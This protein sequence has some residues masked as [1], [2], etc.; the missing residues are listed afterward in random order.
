MWVRHRQLAV[1]AAL[2]VGLFVAVPGATAASTPSPQR[3]T[4]VLQTII[5]EPPAGRHNPA[6]EA[7]DDTTKVLRVGRTMVPLADGS[8]PTT[9]DGST[10]SVT[11]APAADGTKEVL[12]ADTVSAPADLTVSS[13]H[14]VYVALVLP[15]GVSTDASITDASARAMVA[16]V[17]GYWSS[18]TGGKVSFST[19]QVLPTYRSAYS[20]ASSSSTYNMWDEALR[21]MPSAIGPGKHLVLVAPGSAGALGCPYGLGSV[22]AVEAT[23]N[24]VF[25]SSLNQSLLA[26]E[27]GHNLGLYHSNSLRCSG[28]QDVTVVNHAFPG[29]QSNAYD[30]LFDV[31]GYSGTSYGEGNLNAVHL[32]GMNLLPGAVRKIAANSGVTTARITP[33]STTADNRTLRITDPGGATYFV[34]Y[35]TNS[36]RDT[37]AARNPWRP[38]WG[39]RVLRSDPAH[40]ASSG[41]YELDGT[42]TSLSY[43]YNRSIPVGGTFTSASRGLTIRVAAQDTTGATLTIT[44][45]SAPLVPYR[46]TQSVPAK[47]LVG[48]GVTAATRVT[49]RQGSAVP[50]WTVTLQ[51]QQK[52]TTTWRSVRSLRTGSTGAASYW[53]A[54]GVS[55]NYRWVTSATT[56]TPG[57]TSASVSLTS[58]ARVHNK[59]PATSMTRATYLSVVGS[60][61]PV[62]GPVVYI[63]YRYAGG[64]WQTGPR[65]T[66]KGTAVT[67]R[68]RLSVRTTA[69][70]RLYVRPATSYVGSI[71]GYHVTTVR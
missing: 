53:F 40:P 57:R 37:V 48:A 23:S 69:Y 1:P 6:N 4:G 11:V 61:S 58:T 12:A 34:E 16:T 26:H 42:P 50:N 33:L 22:G 13:T 65:A 7:P 35:R 71:S 15:A 3:I 47:A 67:G 44:D 45:V 60:V 5:H 24:V 39:V 20:C 59:V 62:P 43:D 25:V 21:K 49:N 8:L 63:Q 36:G 27:L 54:N 51:K 10:V 29:C 32:D 70:T 28:T 2:V 66:V 68:I 46:V 19:A 14:Q 30:D 17:S 41:S 55:G 52:G 56:G 38:A 31:M 64:S 18:Q 9:K